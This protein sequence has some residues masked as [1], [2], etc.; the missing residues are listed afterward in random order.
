MKSL[1]RILALILALGMLASCSSSAPE[2][3]DA[4]DTG[5]ITTAADAAAATEETR[6]LPNL[7]VGITFNGE[8]FRFLHWEV[9]A[10]GVNNSKDLVAESENGDLINDAVYRRNTKIE[11]TYDVKLVVQYMGHD[12]LIANYTKLVTSSDVA[13][14]VIYPH[15]ATSGSLVSNG[16]YYDLT[17][18]PHVDFTQPWW[19]QASVEDL[20]IDNRLFFVASDINTMDDD[21]TACM[22]FNKKLADDYNLPDLYE[23]VKSEKWTFDAM[24]DTTKDVAG[25][26][27]GDS[28]MDGSDRYGIVSQMDFAQAFYLG[29]ASSFAEKDADDLPYD[30]FF[31]ER[32]IAVCEKIL[33][34]M[35][36]RNNFLNTHVAAKNGM[37]FGNPFVESRTL[38]NFSFLGGINSLRQFEVDFG[39]LPVPKYDEAQESYLSSISSHNTAFITVPVIHDNPEKVGYILEAMAAESKYTLIPAYYDLNLISKGLRDEQS[40]EMLDIIVNQRVFDLGD[41]F[42]FG[43]FAETWLYMTYNDQ[44][45]IASLYERSAKRITKDI[46]KFVEKVLELE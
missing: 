18:L 1:S 32:N 8:D 39:I 42:G 40:E 16:S 2:Q 19:D 20:S 22:V 33:D 26:L 34:I 43:G 45:D 36:D 13:Y 41:I 23:L 38:Y 7:P 24:L 12:Q 37:S 10:W 15:I 9:V 21:A 35:Y 28:V 29:A 25:D 46:E 14:E 5:T 4:A 3:N 11:D 6:I 27:N 17:K 30:S 44:R 31:N